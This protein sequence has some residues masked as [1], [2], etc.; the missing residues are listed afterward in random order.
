MPR[1]LGTAPVRGSFWDALIGED[2]RRC[3]L[4]E[5]FG[6]PQNLQPE[7]CLLCY[8]CDLYIVTYDVHRK[9]AP[10]ITICCQMTLPMAYEMLDLMSD[11]SKCRSCDQGIQGQIIWVAMLAEKM[12]TDNN[13]THHSRTSPVESF[14]CPLPNVIP[15]SRSIN[16]H[17]CIS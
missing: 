3:N 5:Q 12:L 6:V 2:I 9:S 17:V 15:S 4:F 16:E 1:T 11:V 7:E 8:S 10:Y 14:H 13:R